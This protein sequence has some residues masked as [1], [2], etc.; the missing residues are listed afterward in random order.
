MLPARSGSATPEQTGA[1]LDHASADRL[2]A[3]Y[4][5]IT[6]RALRRGEAVGRPW[7][8]VDLGSGSLMVSEQIVQLGYRT[9]TGPPKSDSSRRPVALNRTASPFSSRTV[10]ARPL[11]VWPGDLGGPIADWYSLV[12]TGRRYTRST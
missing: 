8:E 5:L 4:H 6:F 9:E 11:R 1:F 10:H 3:I 2:Y 7:A 12:R